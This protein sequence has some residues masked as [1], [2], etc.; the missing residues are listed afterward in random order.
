MSEV[1]FALF[2]YICVFA[3]LIK[4]TLWLIKIH[5]FAHVF[6]NFLYLLFILYYKKVLQFI[7]FTFYCFILQFIVVKFLPAAKDDNVY[8]EVALAKWLVQIDTNMIGKIF[9]PKNNSI[10]GKLVRSEARADETWQ[11]LEV[12]VKRYYGMFYYMLKK[13]ILKKEVYYI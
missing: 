7:Y 4:I 13:G 6:I 9:W 5:K 1:F 8:Y 2:F 12:E 11:Q 10:A 3:N